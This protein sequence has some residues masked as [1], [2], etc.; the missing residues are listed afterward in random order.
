MPDIMHLIRI[1]VSPECVYL[2]LSRTRALL[3]DA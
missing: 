1:C 3:V 2:A